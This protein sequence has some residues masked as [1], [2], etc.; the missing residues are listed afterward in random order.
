MPH[1]ATVAK[2]KKES[3]TLAIGTDKGFLYLY[4]LQFGR[5]VEY[6][7]FGGVAIKDLAWSEHGLIVGGDGREAK[8]VCIDPEDGRKL[9]KMF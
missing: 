5:Q 6:Q 1:I 2:P 7:I 3:S 4:Y 8:A 9:G